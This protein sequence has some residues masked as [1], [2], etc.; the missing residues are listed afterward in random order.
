[1]TT[2]QQTELE[3]A[4]FRRLLEHLDN[5]KQVQNIELMLVADFCRNCLSKWY[6]SEAHNANVE[7]SDEQARQHI[8]KM[9]YAQWK[10]QHQL[11]A[12]EEQMHAFKEKE[13]QKQ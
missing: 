6:L 10:Q 5:N 9:P 4:T 12:T 7:L 8:Y 2:D 13:A 1:M 11:P 3:A